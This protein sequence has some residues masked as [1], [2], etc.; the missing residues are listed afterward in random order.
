MSLGVVQYVQ[1][2][3]LWCRGCAELAVARRRES[4]SVTHVFVCMYV[5]SPPGA[6]NAACLY[7]PGGLTTES[8][9]CMLVQPCAVHCA[10]ARGRRTT[11]KRVSMSG[12]RRG[13]ARHRTRCCKIKHLWLLHAPSTVHRDAL[14]APPRGPA[15]GHGPV[16]CGA[17]KRAAMWREGR[18]RTP[19]GCQRPCSRRGGDAAAPGARAPHGSASSWR[20]SCI[21]ARQQ[22]WPACTSS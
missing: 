15:A 21:A 14:P 10:S 18:S 11:S 9:A 3:A 17:F 1:L 22:S 19:A 16:Q 4:P 5:A 6:C 8:A 20:S 7:A 13:A 2:C 12:C